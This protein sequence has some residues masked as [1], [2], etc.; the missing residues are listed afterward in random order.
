[1]KGACSKSSVLSFSV[2][3]LA[4]CFISSAHAEKMKITGNNKS[5]R[6][7]SQSVA[8]PGDSAGHMLMQTV[9][10]SKTTSSNEVWNDTMMVDYQQMDQ[11]ADKGT[12]VGYGYHKH[13][14]EDQSFFKYWGTQTAGA[15]GKISLEGKFEFT[16]GT[17]KFKNIKGGGAYTCTGT[18]T[19][20]SCDWQGEV[21][22]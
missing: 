2:A 9:T 1:M 20:N 19:E 22:Y 18:A 21:E 11:F 5:E 6:I 12:H 13:K 16:G 17:G 7:I 14:G 4:I 10:M 15:G 8:T 3:I